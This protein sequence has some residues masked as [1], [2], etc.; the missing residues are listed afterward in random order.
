VKPSL[1]QTLLDRGSPDVMYLD[2]DIQ[3]FAPIDDVSTLAREHSIV[4]TPHATE[5]IPNDGCG[6]SEQ[7][8]MLSGTFNLGFIAVSS[9]ARGFLTWWQERLARDC[10]IAQ[11][12]GR[13]VD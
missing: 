12:E 9:G 6:I 4:L 10:R 13:F 3:F 7:T 2:P 1:L 11:S 5:P 8:I